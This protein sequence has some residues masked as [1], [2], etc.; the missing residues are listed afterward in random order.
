MI[1]VRELEKGLTLLGAVEVEKGHWSSKVPESG[2]YRSGSISRDG[3]ITYR[4]VVDRGH[5]RRVSIFY[6]HGKKLFEEVES[7]FD[8]ASCVLILFDTNEQPFEAFERKPDR[9]FAQFDEARLAELKKIFAS[10]R[11]QEK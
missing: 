1:N 7:R 6:R 8:D 11:A 10:A 4:G 9:T 2:N 5:G 3:Q